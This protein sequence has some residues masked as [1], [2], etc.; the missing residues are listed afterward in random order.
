MKNYKQGFAI[1]LIIAFIALLGIGGG[2]YVYVNRKS[3]EKL[4]NSLKD[5]SKNRV[6]STTSVVVD[7]KNNS[8]IITTSVPSDW[9][10]YRDENYGLSFQYPEVIIFSSPTSTTRNVFIIDSWTNQIPNKDK[11]SIGLYV[12]NIIG[13][14]EQTIKNNRDLFSKQANIQEIKL[15]VNPA[16][17]ISE[18]QK[19]VSDTSGKESYTSSVILESFN[20]KNFYSFQCSQEG[21]NLDKCNQI[22]S[23]FKFMNISQNTVT[24]KPLDG[25]NIGYIKS[26]YM[27]N[28][29][30]YLDIDYIQFITV[31][32]GAEKLCPDNELSNGYCI[33]NSSSLIRTFPISDNVIVKMSTFS[34]NTSGNFN[35]GEIV[36]LEKFIGI[37]DGTVITPGYDGNL[38]YKSYFKGLP[39]F[40]TLKNGIVSEIREKYLP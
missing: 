6:A 32:T 30:Y 25:E 26:L 5:V 39:Y 12:S 7:N 34:H 40:V 36:S 33:L 20:D 29:I 11:I 37:L 8:E 23:T 27:K 31:A 1:P 3:A 22:I 18:I 13:S 9:K 10:T 21:S 14:G 15:G 24:Q 17:K 4:E 35:F 28:G 2:S 19:V 16:I 38:P